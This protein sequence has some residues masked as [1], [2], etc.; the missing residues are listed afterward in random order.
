MDEDINEDDDILDEEG[1]EEDE[2]MEEEHVE[3]EGNA[4]DLKLKKKRE[5][6]LKE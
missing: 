4:N 6:Y 5:F 2:E 3:Q 1:E